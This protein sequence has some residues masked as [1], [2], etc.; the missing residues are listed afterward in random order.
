M[1]PFQWMWMSRRFLK[2]L[3]HPNCRTS[4]LGY[5]L[6][7]DPFSPP[8]QTL[9]FPP[10]QTLLTLP[11]QE[12]PPLVTG[13]FHSTDSATNSSLFSLSAD[14]QQSTTTTSSSTVQAEPSEPGKVP[15]LLYLRHL[16][17]TRPLIPMLPFHHMHFACHICPTV[18]RLRRSRTPSEPRRQTGKGPFFS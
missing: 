13:F 14:E 1:H 12:V 9:L 16:I 5:C 3:S 6:S 4:V 17:G 2:T 7:L 11:L 10:P 15:G 8:L 18:A